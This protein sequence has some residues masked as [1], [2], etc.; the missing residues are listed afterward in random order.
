MTV[1]CPYICRYVTIRSYAL[2]GETLISMAKIVIISEIQNDIA[3][4][5]MLKPKI[6]RVFGWIMK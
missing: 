2:K 4:K 6:E 3:E 1:L 5:M